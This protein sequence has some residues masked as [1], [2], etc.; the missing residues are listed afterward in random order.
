MATVKIML[1]KIRVEEKPGIKIDEEGNLAVE[2]NNNTSVKE[3]FEQL[4]ISTL[5]KVVIVNQKAVYDLN[6]QLQ[7]NDCLD[8]HQLIAGG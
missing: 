4:G 5:G 7:D 2:I 3:L 8:I 6:L 1:H